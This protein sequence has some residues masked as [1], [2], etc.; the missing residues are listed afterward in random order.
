MAYLHMLMHPP[1]APPPPLPLL[2]LLTWWFAGVYLHHCAYRCLQVVALRLLRV[3]DLH[4]VQ[5]ARHLAAGE[6]AAKAADTCLAS[7]EH[8]TPQCLHPC[9]RLGMQM[10][11][12]PTTWHMALGSA[13]QHPSPSGVV[14]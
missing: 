3:E 7:A 13:M 10:G 2:L 1:D 14:S 5:P 12:R 8:T 4:R 11:S 6:K 9:T